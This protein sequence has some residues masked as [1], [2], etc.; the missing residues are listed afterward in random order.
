MP[1]ITKFDEVTP[2]WLSEVLREEIVSVE[3]CISSSNW[4][5][6][7]SIRAITAT[8]EVRSLWL[9]LCLAESFG[10]SEVDYYLNDYIGLPNA[11]IVN[12]YDAVFEERV[13]YHILLDDL[14]R[15]FRDRKSAQPT[16]E[17]G[18][19]LA[20]AIAILHSHHWERGT[21]PT[22]HQWDAYFAH[23]EPGIAP[24]EEASGLSLGAS[25]H[26]HANRLR[27]RCTNPSG[28]TLLHG[29]INPTNVLS[30]NEA[31]AP[32]YLLDRQ[33]FGWSITYGL[34][35]YDLAYAIVPW[36]PYEFRKNCQLQILR[37]WYEHL[38][39]PNYSWEQALAD[40]DLS[41]E[42]CFHVPIEW[43]RN[44]DDVVNMR[45]LWAWQFENI[46]GMAIKSGV[47]DV[48]YP[49]AGSA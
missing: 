19:A 37:H 25:F 9:K 32:V 39:Q 41:V 2:E 38:N 49:D 29:D 30:P 43:C 17:H 28:L 35:A 6:N 18:L 8:G 4:A 5:S 42:L 33:P 26:T 22:E 36:W 48:S 10:R 13:G 11:P 20:Q 27:D 44:P 24:L 14:S 12:C 34:A 45:G 46:T 40:W 16:L 23:V 3:F 7:A 15:E 21:T 31:E 47:A 1:L